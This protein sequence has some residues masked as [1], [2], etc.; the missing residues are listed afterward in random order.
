MATGLE[1]ALHNE[2]LRKFRE[3][4]PDVAERLAEFELVL[5][6]LFDCYESDKSKQ[7]SITWESAWDNAA[8]LLN[9]IDRERKW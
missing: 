4:H 8:D 1:Q 2:S 3:R 7:W 5:N 6:A 9:K